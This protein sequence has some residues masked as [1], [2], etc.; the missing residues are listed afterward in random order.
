MDLAEKRLRF[1]GLYR[2]HWHTWP[3][4]ADQRVAREWFRWLD[5]LPWPTVE[6]ALNAVAREWGTKTGRPGLGPFRDAV[7]RGGRSSDGRE[8]DFKA[9]MPSVGELLWSE[10]RDRYLAMD[11]ADRPDLVT[12]LTL[13]PAARRARYGVRYLRPG[14]HRVSEILFPG[15]ASEAENTPNM[16]ATLDAEGPDGSQTPPEDPN[17]VEGPLRPGNDD[18]DKNLLDVPF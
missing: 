14:F 16:E 8:Y 6:S 18:S 5:P 13:G 11:F 17:A 15:L 7:L 9:E 3:G 12:Y 2:A 1:D 10:Y 4:N